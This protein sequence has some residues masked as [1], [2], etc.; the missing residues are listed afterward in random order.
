MLSP[1]AKGRHALD[2][3]YSSGSV[4]ALIELTN[5][6]DERGVTKMETPGVH[7]NLLQ[8]TRLRP[9]GTPGVSGLRKG[10]VGEEVGRRWP[11]SVLCRPNGAPPRL[12]KIHLAS[13]NERRQL[14]YGTTGRGTAPQNDPETDIRNGIL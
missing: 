3:F 1:P 6:K 9:P 14:W 8:C 7:E 4:C 11:S 13:V 5:K 12:A 10:R 2:V